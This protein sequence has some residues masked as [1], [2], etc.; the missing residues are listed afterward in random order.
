MTNRMMPAG[1]IHCTLAVL[2]I[3]FGCAALALADEGSAPS[4][5]G[6]QGVEERAVPRIGSPGGLFPKTGVAQGFVLQGSQIIAKP[7]Y[8]LERR[9]DGSVVAR[10][11]TGAYR[12]LSSKFE[13]NCPNTKDGRSQGTC[14]PSASGDIAVCSKS[15]GEPCRVDCGWKAGLTSPVPIRP[16]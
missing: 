12:G 9:P 11:A 16:Q 5:P 14:E 2:T 13:C 7:G 1:M 3:G 6:D 10:Q 15:P 8:V 4:T